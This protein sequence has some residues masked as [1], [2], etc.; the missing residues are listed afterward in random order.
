MIPL[1]HVDLSEGPMK[2]QTTSENASTCASLGESQMFQ[3]RAA[4]FK[5]NFANVASQKLQHTLDE[6]LLK[7]DQTA[8][9]ILLR[10]PREVLQ[11][12]IKHLQPEA[13][14]FKSV[15]F[16]FEQ[17]KPSVPDIPSKRVRLD[18]RDSGESL[19]KRVR[20]QL[21]ETKGA[22]NLMLPGTSSFLAMPEDQRTSV[23]N[24]LSA[25]VSTYHQA[26]RDNYH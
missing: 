17:T 13:L 20:Q 8:E 4:L 9:R 24:V 26:Q 19:R 23:I 14:N 6:Y 5:R 3:R 15:T 11:T 12:K 10:L 2:Q 21:A 18:D 16:E 1:N 22:Q 7:V 25:V